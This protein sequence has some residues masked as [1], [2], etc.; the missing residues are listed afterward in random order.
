MYDNKSYIAIK[1]HKE[2]LPN[3]M[4]CKLTNSSKCDIKKMS[5]L[6]KIIT[7]VVFSTNVNQWNNSTSVKEWHKTIP[8]KNQYRFLIFELLGSL[9]L[10][11]LCDVLQREN[12]G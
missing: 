12:V 4:P 8:N 2:H 6:D 7:K 3:K 10:T 9:V 11:N 5:I 1:D